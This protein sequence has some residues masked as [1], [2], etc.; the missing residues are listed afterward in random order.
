MDW[1]KADGDEPTRAGAGA[2]RA[3]GDDVNGVWV[4]PRGVTSTESIY[5]GQNKENLYRILV[6]EGSDE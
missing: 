5:L 6:A 3:S 4:E 2:D 1:L